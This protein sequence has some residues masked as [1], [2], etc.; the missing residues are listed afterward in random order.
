M[1]H[2]GYEWLKMAQTTSNHVKPIQTGSD[3]FRRVQTISEWFKHSQ[4]GSDWKWPFKTRSDQFKPVQTVSEHWNRL[5]PAQN[6]FQSGSDQFRA[7]SIV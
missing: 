2:T 3:Q 4:T 7:V 5:K 6:L 1:D